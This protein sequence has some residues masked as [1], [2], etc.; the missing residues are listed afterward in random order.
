MAI[1]NSTPV[2]TD[3]DVAR[4][5][6]HALNLI[7]EERSTLLTLAHVLTKQ[8]GPTDPDNMDEFPRTTLRHLAELMQ[9]RLFSVSIEEQIEQIFSGVIA[10][11]EARA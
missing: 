6:R 5:L 11:R 7:K 3:G 2:S 9:E 1:A 4:Q 10:S 8:I